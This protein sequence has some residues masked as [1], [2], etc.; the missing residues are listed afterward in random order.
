MITDLPYLKGFKELYEIYIKNKD[1]VGMT[2][3]INVFTSATLN[4]I[5]NYLNAIDNLELLHIV[6]KRIDQ[7]LEMI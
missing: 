4:N 6:K 2:M 7:Y 1:I 3:L 5:K